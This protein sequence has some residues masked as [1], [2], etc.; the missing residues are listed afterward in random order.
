CIFSGLIVGPAVETLLGSLKGG[1]AADQPSSLYE[2]AHKQQQEL[3]DKLLNRSR[4]GENPYLIHNELGDV[5]TKAATVVRYNKELAAAYEKV[6]ELEQRAQRCS[7][8][9]T[10]NWTNQNVVFTKSLR[11]MFPIA[12]AIL[13]GALQRDECRGAHFKP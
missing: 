1:S 7:L 11:D 10:G 3:H 12:K 2:N 4:G 5:M 8:S 13:R 6:S 9:D